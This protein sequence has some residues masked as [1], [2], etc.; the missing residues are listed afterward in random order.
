VVR[1]DEMRKGC[2]GR[3]V[4]H[5]MGRGNLRA[6]S[7]LGKSVRRKARG[8]DQGTQHAVTGCR[9][10]GRILSEPNPLQTPRALF[11]RG[12]V[13]PLLHHFLRQCPC[14]FPCHQLA[15]RSHCRSCKPVSSPALAAAQLLHNSIA[16]ATVIQ[17]KKERAWVGWW[18][19]SHK[20]PKP[21]GFAARG[22]YYLW[23]RCVVGSAG[24]TDL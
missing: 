22:L 19:K 3:E 23:F 16:R 14:G 17:E 20:G 11:G 6:V 10:L 5:L 4:L 7:E 1:Q 2:Q 18:Y 15:W 21:N 13:S 24:G 12:F 9:R 8:R